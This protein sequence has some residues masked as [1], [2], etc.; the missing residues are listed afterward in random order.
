MGSFAHQSTLSGPPAVASVLWSGFAGLT[1][2][3]WL[4]LLGISSSRGSCAGGDVA[5]KTG[6]GLDP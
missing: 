6:P 5:S 1:Q 2:L 3:V 4:I